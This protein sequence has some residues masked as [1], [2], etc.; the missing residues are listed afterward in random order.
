MSLVMRL[1][2]SASYLTF[3]STKTRVRSSALVAFSP[4][5]AKISAAFRL[6]IAVLVVLKTPFTNR[7][8]S[9]GKACPASFLEHVPNQV[10]FG[11][12][13]TVNAEFLVIAVLFAVSLLCE[14]M[15]MI[16]IYASSIVA[17]MVMVLVGRDRLAFDQE[18]GNLV[19][20]SRRTVPTD[21]SVSISKSSG[22]DPATSKLRMIFRDGAIRINLLPKQFFLSECHCLWHCTT[23]ATNE[24]C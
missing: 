17:A 2:V 12:P 23:K 11:E 4:I 16:W 15:K 14:P 7:C 6:A 21:L 1:I 19:G 9:A 20:F 24:R 18:E 13:V 8:P 10:R 22:P 3:P 5:P